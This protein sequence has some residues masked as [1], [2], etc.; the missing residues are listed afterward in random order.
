MHSLL[1]PINFLVQIILRASAVGLKL[2][3]PVPVVDFD[4]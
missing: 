2:P 3:S 4:V 1:L